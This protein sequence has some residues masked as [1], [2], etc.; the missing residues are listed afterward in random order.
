[1]ITRRNIVQACGST[2]VLSTLP[3]KLLAAQTPSMQQAIDASDLIYVTPIR[4]DG[5][6]S[7][8]QSEVWFVAEGSDL[9]IVT[10]TTSWRVR[11]VKKGLHKARIWVGDLGQWQNTNGKY[12]SLPQLEAVVSE[13]D[14]ADQ[15]QRILELFGSKYRLQWIYWGSKFRDGMADGTRTMLKYRPGL[16]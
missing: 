11:A 7:N 16:M 1:M 3:I 12:K 8:C 13:V 4:S 2:L 15:Q 6:E 9:Y 5:S 14:D 10:M